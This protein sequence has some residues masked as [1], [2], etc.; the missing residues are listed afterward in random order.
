MLNIRAGLEGSDDTVEQF[1]LLFIKLEWLSHTKSQLLCA[2]SLYPIGDEAHI[3]P[4]LEPEL[5]DRSFD[6]VVIALNR[7]EQGN[8]Y[9]I[10]GHVVL[11][12]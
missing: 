9:G 1:V 4:N 12:I 11:D 8:G 2:S 6:Y 5:T 3:R 7:Y 10:S